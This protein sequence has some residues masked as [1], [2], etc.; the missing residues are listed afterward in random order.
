MVGNT[1]STAWR[2]VTNKVIKRMKKP[3]RAINKKCLL[4][5]HAHDLLLN[6]IV[7]KKLQ[8]SHLS[9]YSIP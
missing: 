1:V 9:Y 4:W 7:T 3:N 5:R 2:G 6:A 8:F